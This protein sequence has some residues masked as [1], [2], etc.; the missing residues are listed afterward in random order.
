MKIKS[1]EFII[2]A[3]SE[4]QFYETQLNEVA[5]AGKSNV[6]KSTLIN[7]LLN[8]RQLVKTSSTPG[9]TQ[10]I[11]F[12]LINSMFH[13]VDLPGY[14]FAKVPDHVKNQW[15]QLVEVYL[16]QRDVL[17]GVVLIIDV[18]H[19]PSQ[20]D[21]QLKGWLDHYQRRTLIV[22]NK[23]DKLKRGQRLEQQKMIQTK[24]GME[25]L[26]ILHSSLEGIGKSEIWSVLDRWLNP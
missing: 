11:N 24:M 15:K 20:A 26:P 19:G 17:Q 10:L 16:S 1:A 9:K 4:Q 7:S 8:R 22:A 23:A 14:G 21:I 2:S 25:T 5:F 3:A 13:L 6:G 12:F 18:R